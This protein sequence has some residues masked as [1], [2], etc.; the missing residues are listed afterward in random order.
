MKIS[1][2]TFYLLV[3]PAIFCLFS[4][5]RKIAP[6]YA[7]LSVAFASMLFLA[8][9]DLVSLAILLAV[10]L[11]NLNLIRSMEANP[12]RKKLYKLA[13]I[14]VSLAPLIFYKLFGGKVHFDSGLAQ[15]LLLP[16]GLAFYSLQQ[17]TAIVDSA[18]GQVKSIQVGDY[19]FFSFFFATLTSGPIITY[20]DMMGQLR[21]G[22]SPSTYNTDLGISL[23]ILGFAKKTL[24]ADP[25]ESM[26][27]ALLQ[28][29]RINPETYFSLTELLYIFWGGMLSFY[30]VFSAY[31]DMAI[32]IALF[33][34]VRLPVNFNSPLKAKTPQQYVMSWHMSFMAFVRQYVFQP[35]YL[36]LKKAPVKDLNTRYLLAWAGAVFCSFGVVGVWHAPDIVTV[37]I[38]LCVA[39]T[40]V[41]VE[42][43]SL[44]LRRRKVPSS[45][46]PGIFSRVILLS[47]ICLCAIKFTHPDFEIVRAF[48]DMLAHNP[49]LFVSDRLAFLSDYLHGEWIE[50]YSFFPTLTTVNRYEI[51]QPTLS[52][53]LS[54]LHILIV[55]AITFCCPNSMQIFGLLE[56]KGTSDVTP[57]WSNRLRAA[58]AAGVLLCLSLSFA[59]NGSSFSYGG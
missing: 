1:Y 16:L 43:S 46:F 54:M 20:K 2:L 3:F 30:Y 34:G 50:Y 4:L 5:F 24:I 25:I 10:V 17:V 45:H 48:T 6:A 51:A 58:I 57:R 9:A 23:F 8:F 32:G 11:I 14:T 7:R 52:P 13:G 41:C 31:S 28:V 53:D 22:A 27:G 56:E 37:A 38:S 19:L 40:I 49:T 12:H 35:V 18:N 55:T 42:S 59:N 36:L 29:S 39:L 26:T 15:S 44:L 47:F 33:F 21:Q